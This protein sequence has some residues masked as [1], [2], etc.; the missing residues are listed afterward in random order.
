MSFS[1]GLTDCQVCGK[2]VLGDDP[3]IGVSEN[4]PQAVYIPFVEDLRTTG[5]RLLHVTC[6]AEQ[7]GIDALLDIV[8]QHDRRVRKETGDLI[9]KIESL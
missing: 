1:D 3:A 7:W 4:P 5:Y 2:Q 9:R 6:F 8:H